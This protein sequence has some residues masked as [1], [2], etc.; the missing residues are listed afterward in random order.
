MRVGVFKEKI[1]LRGEWFGMFFAVVEGLTTYIF[2]REN[3][4]CIYGKIAGGAAADAAVGLEAYRAL[5]QGVY[6]P[7][8]G[9]E[10]A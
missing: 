3:R 6:C 10:A 4:A 5:R 2:N 1:L 9:G 8:G 7:R